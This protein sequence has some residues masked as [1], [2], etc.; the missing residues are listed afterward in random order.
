MVHSISLAILL[1]GLTSAGWAADAPDAENVVVL[2]NSLDGESIA[3]ARY[4]A[5]KRGIP[6]ANLIAVPLPAESTISWTQFVAELFNPLRERLMEEGWIGA[7][8][9]GGFDQAGRGLIELKG[10]RIAYLVT[11]RG[12]PLRIDN[13]PELLKAEG[14]DLPPRYLTNRAAVD[15]ELSLLTRSSPPTTGVITN[16]LYRQKEPTASRMASVIRV[17][18]LDGPDPASVRRM[19]D[20]ALAGEA[21]G[22]I[23]R[24]YID[25]G[26]PHRQGDLW[27]ASIADRIDALGFDLDR[28]TTKEVMGLTD[29]MD[30]ACLYFGW[31]NSRVTGPFLN[32]GF[33]F[34]PGAVAVHIYSFSA[35]SLRHGW[36]SSLV[37]SGVAVTVGNVYE[38][39]LQLTHNL[40]LFFEKLESGGT[41]GE[42]AWYAL[43]GQSWQAILVGDPLYRPFLRRFDDQW[44][45]RDAA[46]VGAQYLV[47]RQANLLEKDGNRREADRLLDGAASERGTLGLALAYR[48]VL[49]REDSPDDSRIEDLVV[50]ASGEL[51]PDEWG[52]GLEILDW[53]N[54]NG[55]RLEAITV[56]ENLRRATVDQDGWQ[57]VLDERLGPVGVE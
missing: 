10:H 29:R 17:A 30:A 18:R 14:A 15:S 7:D 48:R 21:H 49:E 25:M 52:L 57:Q 13:D 47:L 50:S 38:P 41:A 28:E 3:L 27:M 16:P 43:P 51:R 56:G 4:Y 33:S 23:G 45:K 8:D 11:C 36:V 40:G 6:E 39:Y 32:R 35:G 19:I 26:G 31:H 24:T 55:R 20:S 46:T 34:A 42:A 37:R 2:A 22:L 12:V 44:A 53:L 54:R 1:A 9:P 5:E